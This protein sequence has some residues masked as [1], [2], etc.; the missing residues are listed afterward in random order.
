MSRL[1]DRPGRARQMR[2]RMHTRVDHSRMHRRAAGIDDTRCRIACGDLC[3][4]TDGRDDRAGDC[5]CAIGMDGP[6]RIDS[7][8]VAVPDEMV[9]GFGSSGGR[10]RSTSGPAALISFT[11]RMCISHTKMRWPPEGSQCSLGSCAG[12]ASSAQTPFPAQ[13][14]RVG[15][16]CNKRRAQQTKR[17]LSAPRRVDES[18]AIP[19]VALCVLPTTARS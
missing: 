14:G 3:I 16:G 15:S 13:R 11:G 17:P 10:G 7:Q 12:H 19:P 9:A 5:D 18:H 6:F 2:C 1:P 4:R 8:D